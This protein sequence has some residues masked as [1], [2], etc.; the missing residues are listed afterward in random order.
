MEENQDQDLC[1]GAG[2]RENKVGSL[3]KTKADIGGLLIT[4]LYSNLEIVPRSIFKA[5]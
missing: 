2:W 1:V 3:S 5:S 4:C